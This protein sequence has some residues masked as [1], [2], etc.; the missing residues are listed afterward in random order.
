ME[1][2]GRVRH[3]RQIVHVAGAH[4]VAVVIALELEAGAGAA[5]MLPYSE[6]KWP[7]IS[8]T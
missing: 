6:L 5:V 7:S 1:V 4:L 8:T 3:Q 2:R